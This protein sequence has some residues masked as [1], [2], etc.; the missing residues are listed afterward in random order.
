[1]ICIGLSSVFPCIQSE[2]C[3]SGTV[4]VSEGPTKN[5]SDKS[6]DF[7]IFHNE[8]IAYLDRRLS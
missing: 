4:A 1:M 8:C 6:T 3:L 7:N 2:C 5:V